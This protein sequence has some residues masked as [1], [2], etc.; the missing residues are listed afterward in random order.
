MTHAHIPVIS[1]GFKSVSDL[2][3]GHPLAALGQG[4]LSGLEG[5]GIAGLGYGAAAAAPALF[6]GAAAAAPALSSGAG[7][8]GAASGLGAAAAP[9]AFD[10]GTGGTLAGAASGIGSGLS[11]FSALPE[12]GLGSAAGGGSLLDTIGSYAL[13]NAPQLAIGAGNLAEQQLAR[14]QAQKA[15]Q[16]MT[17][18]IQPEIGAAHQALSAYQSGTLTGPQEA[19]VANFNNQQKARIKQAYANMGLTGSSQEQSALAQADQQALGLKQQYIQQNFGN[20]LSALGLANNV[21]SGIT[22]QEL[23]T[24]QGY[25]NALAKLQEALSQGHATKAATGG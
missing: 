3:S 21:Y 14:S 19:E 9:A 4:T 2:F 12:V 25:N 6:G 23:Q 17:Q 16:Q 8:A 24:A 15:Q 5:A 22:Q 10:L 1:P 20:A 18:A 13:K 7:A 11:G